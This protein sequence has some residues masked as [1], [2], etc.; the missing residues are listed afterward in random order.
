LLNNNNQQH[1]ITFA[2]HN[3]ILDGNGSL[4]WPERKILIFSD[5]HLE[6]GSYLAQRGNPL[7]LHDTH[8]TLQ[9]IEQ[10]ITAYHPEQVISLGDNTHDAKALQRMSAVDLNYLQKICASVPQWVWIIGNHD[11]ANYAESVLK[12]MVFEI[13]KTIDGITF[14]HDL[15]NDVLFQ[16]IGHYHPKISVP[17]KQ[18]RV[19]NV[20]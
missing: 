19:S 4:Y 1:Q 6:K 15:L 20:L 5:V 8:D 13:N 7:P 17:L 11:K 16:M 14:T 10:L 3:F 9:R 2:E 12:D 18:G